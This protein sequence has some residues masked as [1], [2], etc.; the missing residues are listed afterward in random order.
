DRAGM[1]RT[2]SRQDYRAGPTVAAGDLRVLPRSLRGLAYRLQHVGAL[3]VRDAPGAHV[4]LA[5][6]PAVLPGS[7]YLFVAGLC[8]PGLLHRVQRG[9]HRR[10]GGVMG[11]MMLYVIYYPHETFLLFWVIPVPLWAL[12]GIYVLYDLHP[13]LLQLAGD[14]FF[15][16]VAHAG[17]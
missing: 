16:G 5:R 3:L 10:M 11:V 13:V 2:G 4:R 8:R 6:V 9:G 14:Q 15:T 1:A 7:G 17:H 12:L